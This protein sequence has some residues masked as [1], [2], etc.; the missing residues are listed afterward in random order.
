M[1]VRRTTVL[2]P[3]LIMMMGAC[4]G[5]ADHAD[6]ATANGRSP[7]RTGGPSNDPV[8]REAKFVDCMRKAGI[9]M[10]DPLPGDT[11]GRSSLQQAMDRGM[12]LKDAFQTA[13]DGCMS[14]LPPTEQA[15]P[16]SPAEVER[17]REYAKCMRDNG[18]KDFPD[19]DPVTGELNGWLLQGDKTAEAARDTCDRLLR[20]AETSPGR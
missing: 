3:L 2:L 8:A 5:G 19:P 7:A 10:P 18:V 16:A 13:L 9:D 12:A 11:S 20:G 1:W 14:Y 17:R 6:V 15:S 4:G